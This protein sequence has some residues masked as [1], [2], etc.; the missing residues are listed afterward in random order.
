M[1][2]NTI[3]LAKSVNWKMAFYISQKDVYQNLEEDYK[4]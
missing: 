3:K 2:I 1:V 4:R